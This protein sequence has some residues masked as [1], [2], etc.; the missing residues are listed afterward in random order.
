VI[1]YVHDLGVFRTLHNLNGDKC[2]AITGTLEC[3]G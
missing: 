1:P 2:M 3:S